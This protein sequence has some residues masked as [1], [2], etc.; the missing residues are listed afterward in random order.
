M[1]FKLVRGINPEVG[2][3]G[4]PLSKLSQGSDLSEQRLPMQQIW[5]K[6]IHGLNIKKI[7]IEELV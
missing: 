5:I 1:N 3:L 7:C 4:T 6:K 2:S